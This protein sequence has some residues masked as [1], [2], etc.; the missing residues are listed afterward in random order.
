MPLSLA[1]RKNPRV[2]RGLQVTP[3]RHVVDGVVDEDRVEC[4]AQ[5]QGPHDGTNESL[6]YLEWTWDPDPNDE[7]YVVDYAY[8]LRDVKGEV[9]VE[10]DRHLCGVFPRTTWLRL[11]E[12]IGFRA[13]RRTGIAG[14]TAPDIFVG[15]R[16]L[17]S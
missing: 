12:K 13:Q 9:R 8:L 7:T 16:P 5:P 6:R 1:S 17:D 15:V 4:L 10:H 11:M 3:S 2:D 14:E